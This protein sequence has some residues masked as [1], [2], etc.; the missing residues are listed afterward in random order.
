MRPPTGNQD[1]QL[2]IWEEILFASHT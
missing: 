1:A 2:N